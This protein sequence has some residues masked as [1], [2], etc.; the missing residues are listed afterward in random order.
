M[1]QYWLNE[2][3]ALALLGKECDDFMLDKI[4]IRGA[5]FYSFGLYGLLEEWI[6]RDYAE[7]PKEMAN[8]FIKFC[9]EPFS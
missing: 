6:K 1:I 8:M 9:V 5:R 3:S 7:S 2:C 4:I